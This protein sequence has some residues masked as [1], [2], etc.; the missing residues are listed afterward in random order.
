NDDVIDECELDNG[1]K[2]SDHFKLC[3]PI[4]GVSDLRSLDMNCPT[5]D[6]T[7]RI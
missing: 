7:T 1:V 2:I 3:N 5:M 4:D 6:M